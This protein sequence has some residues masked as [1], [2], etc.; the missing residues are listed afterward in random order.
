MT[1]RRPWLASA[2][3]LLVPALA[4]RAAEKDS[5]GDPLPDGAKARL[6]TA[7]M[8][9]LTYSAPLL[10]PDGKTLYAQSN[11]GL[12]KLDPAT[13]ATQGKVPGT[14]YGTP[15]VISADG[16]RA[17]H[18]SY[19]R[20]TVWETETGKALTKIERR[21][22]TSDTPASLSADGNT[23]AIGGV[24]DRAK[25][26]AVTV[27]VWDV[28]TDKEVKKIAVP[29]NEYVNVALS[30]DGKTLA[31]WGSYYDP[32]AK[33]APDPETNPSRFVTFWSVADGKELA[34]FRSSGYTPGAVVFAPNG[35][36]AA[37]ANANSTIDLVD[38]K[39]GTSKNLLLGRSRTGRWMSFS[40][41][42][43]HARRDRRRRL[44]AAV[45]GGR[46]R[47]AL[48]HRAAGARPVHRPRPCGERREG[49]RVGQQGFGH[50]GVGG[51]L[52]HARQPARRAHEHGP[53][54][55]RDR[56]QQVRPHLGRGRGDA[57]VGTGDRQTGRDGHPP[58]AGR[59]VRRLR[60]R[61]GLLPRRHP[62]AA[63]R[64][65]RR[66]RRPRPGD[67]H[68]A[69]RHPGAVRGHVLRRVLARRLEGDRRGLQFRRQ[70]GALPGD[71]VGRGRGEEGRGG[72]TCPGSLRSA[73]P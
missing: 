11:A 64:R 68:A 63:P 25:K 36:L 53:R 55:R 52:G 26:D 41:D 37:V 3:L 62:R 35:A 5:Y 73:P 20:V 14:L 29:Q 57:Q 46:W 49:A 45:E 24:G 51:A 44:G 22:P 13:G 50:A 28:A 10:S 70:E 27:L 4:S 19:D 67:R 16:K 30:A 15:A 56:G 31:T 9:I 54:G 6:G 32:D 2:L 33:G 59:R 58:H 40:P 71:R 47:A 34:K 38:P 7:R 18:V 61:G 65:R 60:A 48:D 69:V 66:H 8:R 42:G 72:S 12:L 43:R 17:A 1:A 39:T 21:L 23:L